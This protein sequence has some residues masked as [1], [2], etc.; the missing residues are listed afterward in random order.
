MDTLALVLRALSD[1]TTVAVVDGRIADTPS[2]ESVPVVLPAAEV[3]AVAC[4]HL[5]ELVFNN[6]G[7]KPGGPDVASA[8]HSVST[9]LDTN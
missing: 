1:H 3:A 6:G 9:Q 8:A 5:N 2:T 4:R 7:P